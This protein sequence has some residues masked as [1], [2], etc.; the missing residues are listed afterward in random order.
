[1]H[2]RID[3]RHAA[4]KT[5]QSLLTVAGYLKEAFPDHKL[6]ALIELR[7]SQ[8]NGCAYC[9]DM[10]SK[11]ARALGE[12]Q[13]R[14]DCLCVWREVFFFSDAERAALAWTESVTRISESPVPDDVF[15]ELAKHYSEEQIVNLTA[16]VG[17][18]NLWNRISISFRNTPEATP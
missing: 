8:I 15:E 9:V 16:V 12:T 11:E 1:M 4:P 7:V 14:L 2:K 18:M 3:Y 17:I 13:Q 5:T 10:H 6:K